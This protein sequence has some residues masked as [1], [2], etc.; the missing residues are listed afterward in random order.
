MGNSQPYEQVLTDR[1]L[2]S[3]IRCPRKA[4]LD[5]YGNRDKRIWTAYRNLQLDHQQQSFIELIPHN[6]GRGLEACQKGAKGVL[7]LRLKGKS[8]AG[9]RIESHPPLLQKI[10]GK[11]IWGKFSYRPVI[12]RQG[13][14]ITKEHKLALAFI[15]ILLEPFQEAQ[16]PNGITVSKN[17]NGLEIDQF[18]FTK[19]LFLKLEDCLSK[20]KADLSLK[21]PPPLTSDRKKCTLCAWQNLCNH[22][23]KREGH[24][25][26]VSGVGGKRR[27]ML[28][29]LGINGIEELASSNPILLSKNLK[30]FGEQH[31][32][33]AEEIITQAKCQR[34]G[35]PRRICTKNSL[36]ELFNVPGIL[37]YDIES[38]PDEGEDF[39]HGFL[40]IHSKNDCKWDI[41]GAKYHPILITQKENEK[42]S[43]RRL[44]K[45]F[46][47]Y[48]NWPI[49][50]YGE[51][52]LL[53]IK[54]LAKKQ[55]LEEKEINQLLARFIDI[56]ARLRESWKLPINSYSL[57][58]VAN[59]IGF[60][61][62]Q[63]R[64]NGAK[65]LLWWRQWKRKP[66][67]DK[68]KKNHLD[69]IFIYNSDDCM[70]TFKVAN[71]LIDQKNFNGKAN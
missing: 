67:E 70:A 4:W 56:H 64:V 68:S 16:V 8:I 66:K 15:A 46:N 25:S 58:K 28:Q 54:R 33:I 17:K 37:I 34:D 36:P 52:E 10:S 63:N 39:L 11:S 38:D 3:W 27:Q 30:K 20:L 40:C 61:W 29:E 6:T 42:V 19:H 22:E 69:W 35:S 2:R 18:F 32:T 21:E 47:S 13:K 1:L 65:A 50:H 41:Q 24:L 45:K 62:T 43:W 9:D 31:S 55:G 59:W 51:T 23:A 48:K 60:Q 12:A 44:Q 5:R 49:L 14:R 57:K 53:V 26:E 71:W 7:G